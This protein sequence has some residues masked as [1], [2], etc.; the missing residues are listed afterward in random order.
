MLDRQMTVANIVLRHPETARVFQDRRID[1]CCR[2]G[3]SLDEA[4]AGRGLDPDAV[5]AEAERAIAGRSAPS[6]DTEVARLSTP[7]LIARIVDRH[8]GYLRETLPWLLQLSAKVAR[9]HGEHNHRLVDLDAAVQ[10][11]ARH[12]IPHLDDEEQA[13]F[14]ALMSGDV[15]GETQEAL[16][17]MFEEHLAVGALLERIR[18]AAEDFTVPEWGCTSYRTLFAELKALETDTLRHVH[19]ENHVLRPRFDT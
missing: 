3:V 9:V 11:L 16:A 17:R 10:E 13:L 19:L 15:D 2:G 6:G 18:T 8:H 5:F 14:P 4:C 12:V 7:G 1:F